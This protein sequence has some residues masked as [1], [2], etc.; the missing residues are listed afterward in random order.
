MAAVVAPVLEELVFRY[1]LRL[2]LKLR[3]WIKRL[4]LTIFRP[5]GIA[6]WIDSRR[7][8]GFLFYSSSIIFAFVHLNNYF[9][10]KGT[11][12][13]LLPFLVL[14]QFIAGLCLGYLRI[15]FNFLLGIIFHALYNGILVLL[16]FLILGTSTNLLYYDGEDFSLKIDEIHFTYKT[17]RDFWQNMRVNKDTLVYPKT[18]IRE[19]VAGA[20]EIDK[21]LITSNKFSKFRTN[22]RIE[23]VNHSEIYFDKNDTLLKYLSE[24]FNFSLKDT[25]YQ[26][27]V[28]K[29]IPVDLEKLY[30]NTA[31][32]DEIIFIYG[33]EETNLKHADFKS[34]SSALSIRFD[35]LVTADSIEGN[36]DFGLPVKKDEIIRVLEE[37]YGIET[38]VDQELLKGC[39]IQFED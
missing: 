25:F 15:R 33:I 35:E 9:S 7:F 6:G 34:L 14:P 27:E 32:D 22:Y 36:F 16:A 37:K 2:P 21:S 8:F 23:M 28:Y 38:Q 4:L 31:K 1:P 29:I 24:T 18:N 12:I 11:A 5:L 13:L 19:L 17:D 10:L 30:R 3:N 39:V 20:K 26:R